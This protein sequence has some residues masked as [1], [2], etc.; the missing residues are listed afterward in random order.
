[1]S[2]GP[3]NS[4]KNAC[5]ELLAL[6]GIFA[7]RLN[8]GAFSGNYKGRKWFMRCHSLGKGAADILALPKTTGN[9][10]G[11]VIP[12]WIETKCKGKKQ[13]PEQRQFEAWVRDLGHDYLLVDD[14]ATLMEWLKERGL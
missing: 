10:L 3:E 8:S 5:L 6:H 7:F 1:M 12:L 9:A 11:Y 2:T 4:V 13:R 14:P